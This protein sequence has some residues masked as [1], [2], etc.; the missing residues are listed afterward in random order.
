MS[1]KEKVPAASLKRHK[2]RLGLP[3][4]IKY[5]LILLNIGYY[6]I[7]VLNSLL[8]INYIEFP[9]GIRD[10]PSDFPIIT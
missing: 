5:Q 7:L 8:Y 1:K 3:I 6:I 2:H 4:H 9:S 10:F